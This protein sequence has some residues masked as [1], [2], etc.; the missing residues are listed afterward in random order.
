MVFMIVACYK[1]GADERAIQGV[2]EQQVI[3]E[4]G[5]VIGEVYPLTEGVSL[6]KLN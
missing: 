3:R 4:N 1:Q 2:I 6:L 5:R